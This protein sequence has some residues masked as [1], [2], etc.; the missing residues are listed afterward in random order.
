[1]IYIV[2]PLCHGHEHAP[3]NAALIEVVKAT[4]P[5]SELVFLGEGAHIKA[6]QSVLT[7][8]QQKLSFKSVHIPPRSAGVIKRVACEINLLRGVFANSVVERIIVASADVSTL[9]ALNSIYRVSWGPRVP[10]FVVL[11]SVL[12]QVWGRWPRNPFRRVAHVAQA[13]RWLHPVC[14]LVVLEPYIREALVE[15]LPDLTRR[16]R[17]LPHP[18]PVWEHAGSPSRRTLRAPVHFGFLGAA[19]AG[20]GFHHFLDM[21]EKIKRA[22]PDAA[23]FS[24]IGPLRQAVDPSRLELLD[25]KPCKN[26]LSRADFLEACNGID[27]AVMPFG[28]H[29]RYAA[30][31]TFTDALTLKLPIVSSDLPAFRSL[32]KEYGDVG[33]VQPIEQLYDAM[34]DIV[35]QPD[36]PRYDRQVA[37]ISAAA[38]AR[39]PAALAAQGMFLS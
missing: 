11:H 29:Y 23:R 38:E 25:V 10:S 22:Y 35:L 34:L 16:I 17:V 39:L 21:A 12:A 31:G 32:E 8:D 9:Y 24:A 20:K 27:Y 5:K 13:L 28:N 15:Q 18:I 4:F 30:S 7:N 3:F 26:G 1:M 6:V 37:A 2:E 36:A 19:N 33:Y 14:R